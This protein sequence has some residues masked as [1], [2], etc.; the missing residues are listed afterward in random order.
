MS[1]RLAGCGIDHVR[2]ALPVLFKIVA[3]AAGGADAVTLQINQRLNRIFA[4]GRFLDR[5]APGFAL[6][7]NAAR[8]NRTAD[9]HQIM[10]DTITGHQLHQLIDAIAFA[11][12]RE[13]NIHPG[14]VLLQPFATA[15]AE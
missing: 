5:H 13:I 12:R 4:V 1:N 9:R 6:P 7:V 14:Q 11:Q 10:G 2:I 8:G 3:V 15:V